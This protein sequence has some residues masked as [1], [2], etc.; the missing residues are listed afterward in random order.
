MNSKRPCM[1]SPHES[2]TTKKNKLMIIAGA[3]LS[4]ALIV[5]FTYGGCGGGGSS[6]SSG[7]SGIAK[8]T[9]TGRI[10]SG[11]QAFYTPP[12]QRFFDKFLPPFMNYAYAYGTGTV[13]DQVIAIKSVMGS[14]QGMESSIS[15]TINSADGSF[16]IALEK[17]V[18]WILLLVNSGLLPD[19]S[20]FIGY[21]ALNDGS[22]ESLLQI[23]VKDVTASSLDLGNLVSD[24]DTALADNVAITASTF[25]MSASQLTALARNDDFFKF[26][27]NFYLNYDSGTGI[28]WTM[29]PNFSWDTDYSA[30]TATPISPSYTYKSYQLLMFS[31]SP[32][33]NMDNLC[34]TNGI[35]KTI[36][37]LHP[38]LGSAVTNTDNTVVYAYDNPLSNTSIITYTTT[39]GGVRESGPNP[40]MFVRE[41]AFPKLSFQIGSLSGTIP[42]GLWSWVITDTG[43]GLGALKG[44]YDVAVGS[45]I[46]G[47]G[48]VKGFVPVLKVNLDDDTNRRITSV[49]VFWFMLNATEDGYDP[50]TDISVLKYLVDTANLGFN[51]YGGAR[52]SETIFFNPSAQTHIVPSMTWYYN[53]PGAP[54]QEDAQEISWAY[55]SGGCGFFFDARAY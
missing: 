53:K 49:Q 22:G 4:V 29:K 6:G 21:V 9:L 50:V 40:D 44:Q 14:L 48:M 54:N 1:A 23:P 11:Y 13:V 24:T 32:Q 3:I 17:N 39:A 28:Y 12:P 27:K 52:R 16:N 19:P 51:N 47:N 31:N 20:A 37:A 55:S 18:D 35:T 8:L 45:P 42:T 5:S 36:F 46:T 33:Y 15:A 30:I 2:L 41:G 7:S 43:T 34:G 25:A 10:G 38:P 26:V